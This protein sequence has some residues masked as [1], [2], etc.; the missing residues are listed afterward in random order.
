MKVEGQVTA[1]DLNHI[2]VYKPTIIQTPVAIFDRDLKRLVLVGNPCS[3]AGEDF[4]EVPQ[5]YVLCTYQL[6]F[7]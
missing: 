3:M 1:G 2:R 4:P 6:M 5:D 7:F